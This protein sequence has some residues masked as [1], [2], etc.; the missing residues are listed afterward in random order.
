M[1]WIEFLAKGS[2]LDPTAQ[3]KYCF[4]TWIALYDLIWETE[5][6]LI[7]CVVLD[8]ISCHISDPFLIDHNVE[9]TNILFS[10]FVELNIEQ[11][12]FWAV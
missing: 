8:R 12:F 10:G 1:S 6:F 4:P 9:L 2:S 7:L 3:C 5:T 11:T